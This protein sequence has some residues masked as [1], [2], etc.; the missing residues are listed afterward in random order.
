MHDGTADD[1][2]QTY[3]VWFL[4]LAMNYIVMSF[5]CD[6]FTVLNKEFGECYLIIA[7]YTTKTLY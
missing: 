3:A 1:E 4:P 5:L 6:Q 7:Y 2:L